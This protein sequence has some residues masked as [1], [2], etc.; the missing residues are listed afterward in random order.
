[1]SITSIDWAE[2]SW[3]PVTGCTKKSDGCDHCYAERM[4]KRLQNMGQARY[5]NGFQV[6]MHESVLTEPEGWA[7]PSRVFV[8]S[9]SDLFHEYVTDDFIRRVFEKMNELERHTFLVLTKRP[10]R[11][12]ALASELQFTANI[13]VGVTVEHPHY[14]SRIDVLRTI[15]AAKRWIS[16]EPL[17]ESLADTDFTGIDWIVVGGESG[18]G[19]RPMDPD[20][21]RELDMQCEWEGIAFFYKQQGAKVGKGSKLLDGVERH[22]YPDQEVDGSESDA[23]NDGEWIGGMRR[24]KVDHIP[25]L[26]PG[27]HMT[28]W[29][30]EDNSVHHLLLEKGLA[31]RAI[32][33]PEG[34]TVSVDVVAVSERFG[35]VRALD[36]D[37]TSG[38]AA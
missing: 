26:E 10:E 21:A 35:E 27:D 5:V 23:G 36:H 34:K 16:C 32:V 9:M 8:C 29:D 11:L 20:W 12:A 37:G 1:M 14:I 17:L 31:V 6:T 4:A 24:V 19:A 33:S 22:Q 30:E 2:K 25:P 28:E 38:E 7:K 13:W 3:N 15:P 18:P